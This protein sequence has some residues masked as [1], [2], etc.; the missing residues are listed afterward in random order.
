MSAITRWALKHELIVIVVWLGLTAAG[1]FAATTVGSRLTKGL[2]LPGQPAYEANLTMLRTF[3]IDGH[4]QPTIAVLHLPVGLSMQTSG[5]RAAAARTL[6]AAAH[7]GPVGIID[8][9]T[10]HDPR[11]VSADGRT[12]VAIYDMPSPDLARTA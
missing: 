9:A 4:Q 12:T 10:P 5:G 7:A 1:A 11:L 3:G 6:A 8:Y 2:P